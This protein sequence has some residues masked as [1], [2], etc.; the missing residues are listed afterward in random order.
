MARTSNRI[1]PK[2]TDTSRRQILGAIAAKHTHATLRTRKTGIQNSTIQHG[3]ISMSMLGTTAPEDMDYS[4]GRTKQSFKDETDVNLI[5]QK[6]TR[7]GTLS[8]LEQWGGQYGDLS[9]FDFQEA[10]N[11]IAKATSMFEELPAA[12]RKKFANSPEKFLEFVNHPDNSDRLAEAL[13]ELAEPGSAPLPTPRDRQDPEPEP[14][15][16]PEPPEDG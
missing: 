1:R 15:P 12:V 7:M 10:Q 16:A 13:P 4:D 2:A 6:H 9:D 8:H 3:T 14:E 11:Q 5:I